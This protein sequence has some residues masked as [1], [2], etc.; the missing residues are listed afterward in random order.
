MVSRLELFLAGW[1]VG[2]WCAAGHSGVSTYKG[3]WLLCGRA[4]RGLELSQAWATD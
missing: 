4:W 1:G 2:L 3:G